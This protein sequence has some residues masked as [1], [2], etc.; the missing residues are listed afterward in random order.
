MA[1]T[2]G[3]AALERRPQAAPAAVRAATPSFGSR[4]SGSGERGDG[5]GCVLGSKGLDLCCSKS[6]AVISEDRDWFT[7]CGDVTGDGAKLERPGIGD[8]SEP[9][10]DCSDSPGSGTAC[11]RVPGG[12][13]R[14]GG[15]TG[16]PRAGVMGRS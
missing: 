16:E 1:S 14:C 8:A 4:T 3:A 6:P 9:E 10:R 11:S 7:P 12:G 2:E 15:S 5:S 13:W